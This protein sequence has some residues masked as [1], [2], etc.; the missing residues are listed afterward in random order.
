VR[1]N[2]RSG[3]RSERSG[4]RSERSGRRSERSGRRSERSGRRR[5]FWDWSQIYCIPYVETDS[6]LVHFLGAVR[7]LTDS[8]NVHDVVLLALL[9]IQVQIRF[10]GSVHHQKLQ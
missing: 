5:D 9:D 1:S 10:F 2:E 7:R 8:N 6:R 4:R 3:R